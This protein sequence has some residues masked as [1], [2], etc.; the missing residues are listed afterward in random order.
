MDG[1]RGMLTPAAAFPPPAAELGTPLYGILFTFAALFLVFG[2]LVR[3]AEGPS[4]A[5][6][7]AVDRIAL[8]LSAAAAGFGSFEAARVFVLPYVEA[9]STELVVSGLLLAL[10]TA[11]AL[12]GEIRPGK[13]TA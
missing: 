1:L 10:G 5:K 8:R 13:K 11:I 12:T 3:E 6:L 9:P 7:I 2:L 4:E